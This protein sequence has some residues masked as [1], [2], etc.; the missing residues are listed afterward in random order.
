VVHSHRLLLAPEK[1][2]PF[3]NIRHSK[4]LPLEA[5]IVMDED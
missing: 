3:G 5:V 4:A 2:E 1:K